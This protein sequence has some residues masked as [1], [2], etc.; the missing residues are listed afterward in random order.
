MAIMVFSCL[1][2][3]NA[4]CISSTLSTPR[5]LQGLRLFEFC[6]FRV[7][8]FHV[9]KWRQHVTKSALENQEEDEQSYPNPK[10]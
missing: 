3:G 2:M 4:G 9:A 1:I 6:R 8:G 7:L 10:P 5:W